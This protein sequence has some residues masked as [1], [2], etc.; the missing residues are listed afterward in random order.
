[1][2]LEVSTFLVAFDA[3]VAQPS[4]AAFD[5]LRTATVRL[6]RATARIRIELE[7]MPAA[8]ADRTPNLDKVTQANPVKPS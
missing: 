6:L 5:Q 3:V 1:M 7:R 8:T 2:T 4:A